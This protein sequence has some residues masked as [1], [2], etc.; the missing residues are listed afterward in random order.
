MRRNDLINKTKWIS[1]KDFSTTSLK[2][3]LKS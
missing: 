2:S 3:A 1:K